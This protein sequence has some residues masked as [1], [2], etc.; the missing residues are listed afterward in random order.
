[1]KRV[2]VDYIEALTL[3]CISSSFL[4]LVSSPVTTHL[5][6]MFLNLVFQCNYNFNVFQFVASSGYTFYDLMD[7]S[8]S[9][10]TY[11]GDIFSEKNGVVPTKN[12][13]EICLNRGVN[14]KNRDR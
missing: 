4:V 14:V 12:I 1:M 11:S 9:D 13:Y 3:C 7:G 10:G 6:L 2:Y 8:L 5:I